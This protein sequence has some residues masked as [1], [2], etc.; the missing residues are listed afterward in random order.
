M[1]TMA[2]NT[3]Y[4][5]WLSEDETIVSLEKAQSGRTTLEDVVDAL[6]ECF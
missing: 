6:D 3:E 5:S 2:N 1:V 4:K